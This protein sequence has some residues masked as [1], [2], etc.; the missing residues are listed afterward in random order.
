MASR[1]HALTDAQGLFPTIRT[2]V[3]YFIIFRRS[4]L[5][6]KLAL[7]FPYL[8]II[9][10]IEVNCMKIITH[11]N[12]QSVCLRRLYI[13]IYICVCVC[14]YVWVFKKD[15]YIY[16]YTHTHTHTCIVSQN[17]SVVIATRCY[18]LDGPGIEFPWSRDFPHSS[19]WSRGP[20]R[21]L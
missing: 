17:S 10:V 19:R 6:W 18:V 14:V 8:C 9:S 21:L 5:L 2:E 15:I 4:K 3:T 20:P 16:I 1:Q 13:Y 12:C 11:Q 7:F